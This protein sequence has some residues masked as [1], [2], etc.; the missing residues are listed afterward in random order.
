MDHDTFVKNLIGM[1]LGLNCPDTEE[2][3]VITQSF[4][5]CCTGY[6]QV[7]AQKQGDDW[8]LMSEPKHIRP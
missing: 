2:N 3:G 1:L 5:M 7:T 6:V 8:V 4:E